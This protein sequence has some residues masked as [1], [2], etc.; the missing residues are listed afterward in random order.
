VPAVKGEHV[1]SLVLM[2]GV[3]PRAGQ[4]AS[5]ARAVQPQPDQ[6][7]IHADQP[8]E[9]VGLVPIERHGVFEPSV[10]EKLLALKQHR[11][12]GRGQHQGRR[13][14]A[15]LLRRPAGGVLRIDLRR[16]P[17]LAVRHLIMG[18]AVDHPLERVT[19]VAAFDRAA[20][21]IQRALFVTGGDHRRTYWMHEASGPLR[22]KAGAPLVDR[23]SDPVVVA[24]ILSDQQPSRETLADFA[25]D[26]SHQRPTV[27]QLRPWVV[28]AANAANVERHVASQSV[29]VILVQPHQRIVADEL[30]YLGAAVIGASQS[31]RGRGPPIV[32]KID[33]ALAIFAPAVELPEIE[34]AGAKMVVDHIQDHAEAGLMSR[35]DKPLESQR[36]AVVAF[37]SEHAGRVVAP[38]SKAAKL[39]QGHQ[40]DDIHPQTFQIVQLLERLGELV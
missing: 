7:T 5:H 15:P 2:A 12:A 28:V 25:A 27:G 10:L 16:H 34:V 32:V 29:D 22:G 24:Q 23:Q 21:P 19:V 13:E 14:G 20:N 40:L 35:F 17:R 8:A 18:F 33:P 39:G 37:D 9:L 38:R 3:E 4:T 11:D 6:V 31:P 26:R 36:A 30:S 1:V